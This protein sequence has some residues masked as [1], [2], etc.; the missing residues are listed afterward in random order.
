[1]NAEEIRNYSLKKKDVLETFP[2]G[3]G[4]LVFKVNNKIFLLLSITEETVSINL[5]CDPD[6][7]VELREEYPDVIIP[8]YHMNKKHWNTI[9]PLLIKKSLV[10]EMIDDSY[11]LVSQKKKNINEK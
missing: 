9:Y 3:E 2:F 7:A 8:G 6:K 5:K 4:V 1:M 11:N 10:L